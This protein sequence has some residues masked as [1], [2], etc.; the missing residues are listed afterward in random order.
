MYTPLCHFPLFSSISYCQLY[1]KFLQCNEIIFL[2]WSKL[3]ISSMKWFCFYKKNSS[4]IFLSFQQIIQLNVMKIR[5]FLQF[6]YNLCNE[7]EHWGIVYYGRDNITRPVMIKYNINTSLHWTGN[8]DVF[9]MKIKQCV[10]IAV[11][12]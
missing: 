4:I 3:N 1:K 6:N 8:C 7:I 2:T 10:L 11:V 12:W 9:T 5:N